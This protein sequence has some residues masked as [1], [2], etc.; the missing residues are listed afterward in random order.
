MILNKIQKKNV[1]NIKDNVMGNALDFLNDKENRDKYRKGAHNAECK[2]K[3]EK[4]LETNEV[5]K[6]PDCEYI[7]LDFQKGGPVNLRHIYIK[8]IP[9]WGDRINP[10]RKMPCITCGT[11]FTSQK[12]RR[13]LTQTERKKNF[14][15]YRQ[16]C[17]YCVRKTKDQKEV[18]RKYGTRLYKRYYYLANKLLDLKNEGSLVVLIPI[19]EAKYILGYKVEEIDKRINKVIEKAYRLNE[20]IDKHKN[21]DDL[22]V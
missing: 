7:K 11:I 9:S 1:K 5:K 22:Y 17:N 4:Y 20:R 12:Y 19:R 3:I 14:T 16:Y 10:S 21:I 15:G 13:D 18:I 8:S 6:E 2:K